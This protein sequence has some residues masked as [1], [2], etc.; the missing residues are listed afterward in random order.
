M[1]AA[2]GL[3]ALPARESLDLPLVNPGFEEG[4]AGWQPERQAA[5]EIDGRAAREGQACLRLDTA[6]ET[7]Y[8]PSVR[9]ALP[10]VGPGTYVLRF[11]I[12]TEGMDPPEGRTAGA[13]VSLE[14]YRQDGGRVWPST[15]VFSGTSDWQAV[16]L[17]ALLT[18]DMK[19]G[20]AAISIHRYGTPAS[21]FA[22]FDDFTLTRVL[23]PPIETFLL[24]PN[25]RGYLPAGAGSPQ[26]VR[27]WVRVNEPAREQP[28]RIEVTAAE[29]GRLIDSAEI[30]VGEAER[31]VE[32]D[33]ADWPVGSYE[34]HASLGDYHYPA[35]LIRRISAEERRGLGVWFD[36]LNVLHLDGRPTFPLGL[37]NTVEKFGVVQDADLARL[38]Q[39]QGASAS[40]H[41]NYWWWPCSLDTRRL[42]LT[43]MHERGIW[44]LDTVN[45]VFPAEIDLGA[46]GFPV[47]D[48]LLPDAEGRLMTQEQCD[49]YLTAL[50]GQMRQI[51]AHAGWYVM[52][53]RPFGRIPAQFHQYTVL[54]SADPDHPTYGVSNRP[55]ELP[56]WRDALDVFGL[57]PYPLMN[58]KLS[59][60]LSLAAD[61]TRAGREATHAARPLWMVIQFFQGWSTDRWPTEEELRTMSLMAITEGARGLFYWSMGNR[62][63]RSVSDPQ[64]RAEYWRRV[65]AVTRELKALEPALVAPDEPEIVSSVSDP[66][67]RWTARVADGRWLI[68]A[69]LPAAKFEERAEQPETEV[70]FGLR[71]GRNVSQTLR[72][73]TACWLAVAAREP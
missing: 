69:Y 55:A 70:V 2:G 33:A 14:Y 8:V 4:W 42:Y 9:Q 64:T 18:A 54:R 72:P 15:E 6:A 48:E 39:M 26:H 35:Y 29:T 32:L 17:Q 44:H 68:F 3:T 38:D 30:G 21:G 71:D 28:A 63:L 56:L 10:D 43:A 58:M 61:W 46:A 40:L 65:L 20:S 37:Y 62:G 53:E 23:P 59:T 13:R 34:V 7:Q 19:P 25:Y 51:P 50:A 16:E 47:C 49:Q 1:L 27:L 24:Y 11:W 52:D 12:R 60:P 36:S 41:I 73:D 5:F 22:L 31:V 66:R 45:N 57:D 67:V